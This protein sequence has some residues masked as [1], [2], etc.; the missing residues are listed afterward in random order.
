M[1][2]SDGV[3]FDLDDYAGVFKLAVETSDDKVIFKTLD[4]IEVRRDH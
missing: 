2:N 1:S 4:I 3:N